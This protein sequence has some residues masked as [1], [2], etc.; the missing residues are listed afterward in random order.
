MKNRYW[1]VLMDNGWF[2]HWTIA[3]TRKQAIKTFLETYANGSRKDWS[4]RRHKRVD[5]LS[6]VKVEVVGV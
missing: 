3:Y 5:G 6:V 1:C 4:W 2:C